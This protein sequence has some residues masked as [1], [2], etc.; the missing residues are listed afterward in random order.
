MCAEPISA[1]TATKTIV[2]YFSLEMFVR[3]VISSLRCWLCWARWSLCTKIERR[4][5]PSLV[6]RP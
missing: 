3:F 4:R 2:E 6:R 1:A 5:I